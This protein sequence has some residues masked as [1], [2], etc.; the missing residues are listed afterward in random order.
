MK[1]TAE[2]NSGMAE[3]ACPAFEAIPGA[4]DSGALII[5]DHASNAIPPDYGTLGL[6]REALDRHIAYDI[7]A[8]E[9]TRALAAQLGAPACYQPIRGCSSIRIEA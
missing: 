8:A 1:P 5:C 2:V 7:G 9:V 6:P 3:I 4:L